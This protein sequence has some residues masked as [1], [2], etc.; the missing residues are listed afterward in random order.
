MISFNLIF[1]SFWLLKSIISQSLIVSKILFVSMKLSFPSILRL[2]LKYAFVKV[3]NLF[4]LGRSIDSWFVSS[5]NI[6]KALFFK[7]FVPIKVYPFFPRIFIILF[8]DAPQ[9]KLE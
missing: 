8:N 7:L 5:V 1:S 9:H 4:I 2:S 6:K 3:D